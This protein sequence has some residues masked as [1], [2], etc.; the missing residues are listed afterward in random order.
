MNFSGEPSKSLDQLKLIIPFE[1]N[2]VHINL[3]KISESQF[4]LKSL[5]SYNKLYQSI[6]SWINE[7][8]H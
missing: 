7:N 2:P 1:Q 8:T 5:S 6:Q 4:V 3:L